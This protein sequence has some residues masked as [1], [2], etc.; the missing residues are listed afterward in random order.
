[1]RQANEYEFD[2]TFL[3]QSALAKVAQELPTPFYLLDA[4]GIRQKIRLLYRAFAWNP[5]FHPAFPVRLA[6]YEAV[7]RRLLEEGCG[8]RCGNMEELELAERCGFTGDRISYGPMCPTVREVEKAIALQAQILVDN[9]SFLSVFLLG[10]AISANTAL[11]YNP[12]GKFLVDGKAVSR[13]GKSKLGM[14]LSQILE[15]APVL[16]R[17][18]VAH[19]GLAVEPDRQI[20]EE[21]YYAAVAECLLR[22]ADELRKRGISVEYLDLGGGPGIP[23]LPGDPAPDLEAM[24]SR[25]R[26]ILEMAGAEDLPVHIAP[27][28]WIIGPCGILVSKVLCVKELERKYLILDAAATHFGRVLRGAKHHVSL[29]GK[30]Q[31]NGRTAYDVVGCLPE[32]L[33]RLAERY[34]LPPAEVGDYCVFHSAGY[35]APMQMTYGG[36]TPCHVYL[37]DEDG[38]VEQL[39]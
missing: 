25:V 26:R 33:P 7:L 34:L 9:P 38:T 29:V 13:P 20:V 21:G 15:I 39:T 23:L 1:M 12:G 35:A 19:L 17:G 2:E 3:S 37:Y 18:G 6:P 27:G 16:L 4:A 36:M 24:G 14:T 32:D 28:R 5:G 22:V 11:G 8:V 31:R 10:G 30:T